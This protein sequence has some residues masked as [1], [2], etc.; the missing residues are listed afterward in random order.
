MQESLAIIFACLSGL[1]CPRIVQEFAAV[2]GR[3]GPF[4]T[5]DDLTVIDPRAG[6]PRNDLVG[7]I[8]PVR[9]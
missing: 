2:D 6:H 8:G 3:Y 1:S 9:H 7:L 4:G 5:G